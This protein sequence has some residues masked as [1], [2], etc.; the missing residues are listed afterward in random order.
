MVV[1][2]LSIDQENHKIAY[3][4]EATVYHNTYTF[5]DKSLKD[6][7]IE[8]TKTTDFVTLRRFG[9]CTMDMQ[10]C[11]NKIT[12]GVYNNKDG[13]EFSFSIRTTELKIE[14]SRIRIAYTMSIE[15]DEV[16]QQRIQ[17]SF[18]KSKTWILTKTL[19]NFVNL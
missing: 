9:Y 10:F 12:H 17:F 18:F 14:N 19:D 8:L 7:S 16:S 15:G 11:L 3:Q 13:L 5:L 6:T 4:S 2:F 1:S